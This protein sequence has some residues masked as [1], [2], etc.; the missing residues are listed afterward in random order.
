MHSSYSSSPLAVSLADAATGCAHLRRPEH[1]YLRPSHNL[2]LNQMNQTNL[3][4][5]QAGKL[6]VLLKLFWMF[7]L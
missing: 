4:I 6:R 7:C 3:N 2:Q 5:P 1:V